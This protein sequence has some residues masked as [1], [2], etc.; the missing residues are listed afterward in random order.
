MWVYKDPGSLRLLSVCWMLIWCELFGSAVWDRLRRSMNPPG[1]AS[2]LLQETSGAAITP[3]ASS[4]LVTWEPGPQQVG[5]ALPQGDGINIVTWA[6]PVE[7]DSSACK[8]RRIELKNARLRMT[9]PV[10]PSAVPQREG[11]GAERSRGTP[12]SFQRHRQ[13]ISTRFLDCAPA[14]YATPAL[15]SE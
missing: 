3:R 11:G 4:D 15:R 13:K 9:S 6:R 14:T 7:R 8:S 5:L 12:S 1:L 10:I 2:L